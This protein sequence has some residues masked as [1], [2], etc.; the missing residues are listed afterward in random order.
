MKEQKT[1]K[2]HGFAATILHKHTYTAICGACKNAKQKDNI[3]EPLKPYYQLWVY[4]PRL[5]RIALKSN[6]MGY[7]SNNI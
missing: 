4:I 1:G 7:L 6:P 5:H 3:K 2:I